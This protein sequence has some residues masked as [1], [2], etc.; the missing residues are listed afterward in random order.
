MGPLRTMRAPIT[1]NSAIDPSRL[2]LVT[3]GK[4][5]TAPIIPATASTMTMATIS[6]SC[7]ASIEVAIDPPTHPRQSRRR[8][9][10]A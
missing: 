7:V 9:G 4:C 5:I 2:P 1:T 6:L 10:S 3:P 8:S